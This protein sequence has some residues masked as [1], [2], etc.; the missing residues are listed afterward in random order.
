FA[1]QTPS[2]ITTQRGA[3]NYSALAGKTV[4]SA[5]KAV[6]EM[7]EAAELL[8]GEPE[9]ITHAVNFFE[10]G[11]KPLEIVTSRQWY[12]RNGGRNEKLRDELIA[13]GDELAWHPSFMQSRYTNWVENLTGDW[14]V[15]RQRVFGVASP[16][17]YRLDAEG[18]ADY[19]NAMVPSDS[20]L[21]IEPVDDVGDGCTT[22]QRD[23]PGSD[24]GDKDVLDT[25][26]TASFTPQIIGQ[27]SKDEQ[28]FNKVFPVDLRPQGLDIIRTWLF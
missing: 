8:D 16:L 22:E 10:K 28:Y 18:D 12:L 9:K 4:F 3:E 21:T 11:D 23:V 20:K 24:T 2:W 7:L 1:R 25:W 13:R 15:S 19:D 26:A 5:Q 6:V 27:W 14:L 17:W